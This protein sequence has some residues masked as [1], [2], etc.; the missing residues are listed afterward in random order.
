MTREVKVLSTADDMR[1]MAR[2]LLSVRDTPL[3]AEQRNRCVE[4]ALDGA[5]RAERAAG[6]MLDVLSH[7]SGFPLQHALVNPP[8]ALDAGLGNLSDA[9]VH[10]FGSHVAVYSS[11]MN[12]D[13][14]PRR[15]AAEA[16][17]AASDAL[18]KELGL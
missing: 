2:R 13:P 10:R 6:L 12:T 8:E 5:T 7:F 9:N 18:W 14:Q 1:A 17:Q 16:F 15:E 4:W 3:T 11:I